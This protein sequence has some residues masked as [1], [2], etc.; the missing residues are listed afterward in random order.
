MVDVILADDGPVILYALTATDDIIGR[1]LFAEM[2]IQIE[3]FGIGSKAFV[4]P[5]IGDIPIGDVVGKPFMGGF[6]DDD[7]VEQQAPARS[8][9]VTAQIAV[10]VFIAVGDRTL[11]FHPQ[12]GDLDQFEA[13]LI[14]GVGA[15][16]IFKGPDHHG[17]L[18]KLYLGFFQ[19]FGQY[20]I[21]QIQ[22]SLLPII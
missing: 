2:V 12:I 5:H 16:P 19:V 17:G 10:A 13:V 22:F 6:V 11:V 9:Q 14:K 7:K 18:G 15:K 20:I 1:G 21:I 4:Y 8:T 3:V